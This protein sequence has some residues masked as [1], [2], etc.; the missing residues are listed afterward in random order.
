[1]DLRNIQAAIHITRLKLFQK[2]E[3][4]AVVAVEVWIY[5]VYLFCWVF[6]FPFSFK[7]FEPGSSLGWSQMCSHPP[8]SVVPK[9]Q[10]YALVSYVFQ[11]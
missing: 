10:T 9:L 5:F 3:F 4:A 1:M 11:R 6:F 8:A 2:H 7:S